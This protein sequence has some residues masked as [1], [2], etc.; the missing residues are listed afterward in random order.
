[1]RQSFL[2]FAV[3]LA[4]FALAAQAML[5]LGR[6]TAGGGS[7]AEALIRY[8]SYFTVLGNLLVALVFTANRFPRGPAWWGRFASPSV[9]AAALT[10]IVVVAATYQLALRQ[11]WDPAGLQRLVDLLLHA[12]VP[13]AY[14]LYWLAYAPKGGLR[15]RE[16]LVWLLFPALYLGYS[17][18]RHALTG[19]APYPFLDPGRGGYAG[20]ARAC[21]VLLAAFLA[22]GW[23]VVAVDGRLAGRSRP[24]TDPQASRTDA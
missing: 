13:L 4:W 11:L 6:V 17:L 10:Y 19:E 7:A 24:N 18:L 1:M 21:L 16:P 3:A 20:V 9:Q 12:L 8:L 2:T 22:L 14:L 15:W 5:L 23:T